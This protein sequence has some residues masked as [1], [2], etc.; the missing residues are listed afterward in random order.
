MLRTPLE[1]P[2]FLLGT[3]FILIVFFLPGGIAGL[4]A[5]G[6]PAGLRRLEQAVRPELGRRRARGRADEPQEQA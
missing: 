1:Q 2:L 4:A 6:R 5:R 3:I